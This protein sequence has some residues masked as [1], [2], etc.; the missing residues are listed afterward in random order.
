MHQ[1]AQASGNQQKEGESLCHLAFSH[2]LKLSEDQLPFIEQYAQQALDLAQQAG[3]QHMLARS[4][5]SLALVHQV[6]GNLP[7]SDRQLKAS[8]QVSRRQG[9]LDTLV[10]N[11][12]WL[13]A[14][15]YW[16]GDF[17]RA[18]HLGKEGLGIARSIHDGLIELL[19]LAFL[20][21]T[22]WST[23]HY[24]RALTVLHEGMTKA[25]ERKNLFIVGRLT[26][27][28][29]WFH[30]EFGDAARAVE[31]DQESLELGRASGVANVE[32]SALI[33]LGLDYLALGQ[34]TQAFAYL[35]P[36]LKRVQHEVFGTERWRW[37]TRLLIGLTELSLTTKAYDQALRYVEAGIIEAQ[38]TSS[39]KYVALGWSLRGK[40][41]AQLGDAETAET[42]LQRAFSLAD[43]LQSPALAYPIAYALGHWYESTGKER[44]AP[45]LYGKAQAAVDQMATAV[46]DAALHATFLQ[47]ALVQTINERVARFGK[48]KD[49]SRG[50]NYR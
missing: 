7:E 50:S 12:L 14:H 22:Y 11:L 18:L 20:C 4:L 37:K 43:A 31:Y 16:Q 19:S 9:A 39:Q 32:I 27:T 30:R 5:T 21:Q 17:P 42:E 49:T 10:P 40:I 45:T 34:H 15:A 26:N 48:S 1:L 41:A 6:R 3:N 8:L 36:T 25:K 2:W 23:G 46:E 28:L 44:E 13:S 33:N 38:S 35:E 24:D 47:A 29:G